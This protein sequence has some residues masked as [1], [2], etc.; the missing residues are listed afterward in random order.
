MALTGTLLANFDSFSDACSKAI[1]SLKGFE[2]G[3]ALVTKQLTTV[4]N[5]LSGQ[6]IVQQASLAAQAIANMGG[7]TTLTD[8]EL[9]KV[10]ATAQEAVDKLTA[11]GRD[12]P[13]GIQ[14]L[15]DQARGAAEETLRLADAAQQAEEK[16]HGWVL[17]IAEGVVGGELLTKAFEHVFEAAKSVVE[18]FP[19]LVEHT[20]AVGNSIY[21]MALKT[22][23]SVEGLSALRYVASQT[24]I[25]FDS[26]G[27]I[28]GLMEKNLGTV[29]PAAAKVQ[30]AINRLGLDM[31]TLKNERPDQA[32]IDIATALEQ[33][34]NN[35]DKANIATTLMGRG[36]K[37][38]AALW[39]DDI[40]QMIHDA[41]DLG[42]VM[43]ERTV[44][45]SHLAEIGFKT[46]GM[47]IEAVGFQ[48]G[49][50]VLPALV[51]FE[52]LAIDAF[53]GLVNQYQKANGVLSQGQVHDAVIKIGEALIAGIAAAAGFAQGAITGLESVTKVAIRTGEAIVNVASA[54]IK[55]GTLGTV[56]EAGKTFLDQTQKALHA[57]YDAL[58][59]LKAPL[60]SGASVASAAFGAMEQA[61][62]GMSGRFGAAYDKAG[63]A[64]ADLAAKLHASTGGIGQDLGDLKTKADPFATA[65][66]HL[67]AVGSS[68]ADTL[69]NNISPGLLQ[70][71]KDMLAAGA[72]AKDL[73][74]AWGILPPVMKA[75]EDSMKAAAKTATDTNASIARAAQIWDQYFASVNKGAGDSLATKLAKDQEAYDKAVAL[76]EKSKESNDN[77]YNELTALNEAYL[78]LQDADRTAALAKI[79]DAD[80]RSTTNQIA[81]LNELQGLGTRVAQSYFTDWDKSLTAIDKLRTESATLADELSSAT[82]DKQQ[83]AVAKW[84]NDAVSKLDQLAPDYQQQYDL[85]VTIAGQRYALITKESADAAAASKTSWAT[86]TNDLGKAFSDLGTVAGGTFQAIVTDLKPVFAAFQTLEKAIGSAGSAAGGAGGS[87]AGLVGGLSAGA[88]AVGAAWVGVGVAVYYAI[89]QYVAGLNAADAAATK[90]LNTATFARSLAVDFS[91]ANEFASSLTA[92][93][94]AS[95]NALTQ[96]NAALAGVAPGMALV[97]DDPSANQFYAEALNIVSIIQSLG[98]VSALSGAQLATVWSRL[99]DLFPLIALGGATGAQATTQL[100]QALVLMGQAGLTATGLVSQAFLDMVHQAQAAGVALTQVDALILA[101]AQSAGTGLNAILT[102]LQGSATA[103]AQKPF[104]D[105]IDALNLLKTAAEQAGQSTTNLD[106]QIAALTKQM[107]AT[108]GAVHL[109]QTEF[110]GLS[111]A[112]VADFA[113]MMKQGVSF[114]DALKAIQPAITGLQTALAASGVSGGAAFTLL[115]NMSKIAGDAIEGPLANAIAGVNTSL[116][117]LNNSGILNQDMFTGLA[118]TAVDA[119]TKITANGG[120]SNAALAILQ[121]TMQT[122]WELS[123]NYGYSLD[124]NTKA[125]L[126]QAEAAG[127]VGEKFK[128]PADQMLD[129]TNHIADAMDQLVAIF[130]VALPDAAAA[131][132]KQIQDSLNTIKAPTITVPVV[133]GTPSTATT[134]DATTVAPPGFATGG[135]VQYKAGGG[136]ILPFIP[137]GTDTVPAM[138]TPGERVLTVAQTKAYDA[139][140]TAAA[141]TTTTQPIVVQLLAPDGGV[142]QEVALDFIV[143]SATRRTGASVRLAR[144]LKNLAA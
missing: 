37:E 69:K 88:V 122:I 12:V 90:A 8:A 123:Q 53:Q 71:V 19:Q 20:I 63:A 110:D 82:V 39:H 89:S 97:F 126:A 31:R 36:A 121:P 61:A 27:R 132:A 124:D 67:S 120:D 78:A 3:S 58:E 25:D 80:S 22:G 104:Q 46:L 6:K 131:A 2:D 92:S 74:V 38:M 79:E 68:W 59:S 11:L 60:Q 49:A 14:N 30:D 109:T 51:A 10:G 83:A 70:D 15:A 21:E 76:L 133:I 112:T 143:T 107:N 94:A 113:T 57:T 111:A 34:P 128:S 75:I 33:I 43:S 129:A 116:Q 103:S 16:T 136:N 45:A 23:A 9:Q 84:F 115:S 117:G 7:V 4:S 28:L 26:F 35:A 1:I 130:K 55:V 142:T 64:I 125:L 41:Q 87:D 73:E 99:A 141:P 56:D 102:G 98:G 85:I 72:S 91:S 62:D 86:A 140:G 66:E 17:T 47:Q 144:A 114:T 18:A 96:L 48:I 77:Y 100:D 105:Q 118:D 138:L 24:G 29:G 134:T 95:S 93:I 81:H 50:T 42:L 106:S 108:S 44:A 135:I 40:Q 137:R 101:Q 13:A 127:T 54:M 32:F 139:S 65:M 119:F 5:A 52:Q